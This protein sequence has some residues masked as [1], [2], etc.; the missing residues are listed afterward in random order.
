MT[1]GSSE[2]GTDNSIPEIWEGEGNGKN[3]FSQLGDGKEMKKTIPQIQGLEGNG[4]IYSQ[5]AGVRMLS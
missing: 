4:K 5:R 1:F 2:T 3:P